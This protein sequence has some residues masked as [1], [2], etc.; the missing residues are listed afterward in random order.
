MNNIDI[1]YFVRE[2]EENEELRYSLRSLK[3]LPHRKVHI[4]GYKPSWVKNVNHVDVTQDRGGK[5]LNTTYNMEMAAYEYNI[6]ED[7][8][9]MNDDF[10][11]MKPL[12]ELPRLH[13]GLVT[14][15]EKYY[16]QFDSQYYIG[17]RDTRKY[18]EQLGFENPYSYEL[19]IPMMFNKNNVMDMLTKYYQDQPSVAVL[20]KRSLYGN[21]FDY[22]GEETKDV[23]VYTLNGQFD[24]NSTFLSTQDNIW[25]DSEVGVFI[26]NKFPE[27]CEYEK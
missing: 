25:Q 8:I 22:G 5:N 2:G 27:K 21:M 1:V 15:L 10:F 4:V 3:N 20:H 26:R 16:E 9:L 11:I 12:S 17:M 23:K 18:M 6:S 7:F 14:E 24:K 19:H 13:R